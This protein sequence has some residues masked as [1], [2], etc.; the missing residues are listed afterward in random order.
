[1]DF[2]LEAEFDALRLKTK[3]FIADHVLPL[4][5]DS[6]HYDTHENIA[7]PVLETA[8]Q[9]AKAAGLWAPQAPTERGG[10][11]LPVRGWAAL[12]EEVCASNCWLI[13]LVLM[14]SGSIGSSFLLLVGS[15]FH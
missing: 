11:G 7:L 13:G 10:M 4:E 8:R 2:T 14:L 9:K 5:A 3:A 1:M 12:Y 15:N 6:T